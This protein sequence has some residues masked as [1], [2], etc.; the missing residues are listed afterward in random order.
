MNAATS[1]AARVEQ[2]LA[3][4]RRLGFELESMRYALRS[5]IEHVSKTKHRGALTMELMAA[6]ARQA[7]QGP[8]DNATWARRLKMLRPFTRWLQHFEPA[9]A[10]PE[11]QIFGAIPGR[12]APHIYRDEEIA[13]LLDTAGRIGPPMSPRGA[14][15]RTLFG[16]LACTGMRLSEAL[17][18][19]DADVELKAGLLTIRRSKFGK[20]RLVPLHASAVVAL[21]RYR[22]ERDRYVASTPETPLF[23]A[24]R[25]KRLGQPSRS[26]GRSHLRPTAP[27]AW[28]GEPWLARAPR[29]H[30]L[31][32]TFAVRRLLQWHAQ[33]VDMHQRMLALSTYLGHAKVSNTY[34][35]LSG[36]PELM[37]IVGKRFEQFVDPWQ[38]NGEDD[39]E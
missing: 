17:A 9:T 21:Q 34:W 13:A 30:D 11:E 24:C 39:D 3:E 37:S 2:Y 31:R 23:I 5:L 1:L 28:L 35:Y 18:L 10:V 6:W 36:V 15:I 38:G 27:A 8:G 14:V 33:G 29:V 32:H 22:A 20:S 25:G 16:L 19:T 4:R 26:P 12:T 7:R